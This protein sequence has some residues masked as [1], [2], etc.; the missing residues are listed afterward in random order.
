M[1]DK[2]WE[3]PEGEFPIVIPTIENIM[4]SSKQDLS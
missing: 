1:N 2:F 3:F 4:Y